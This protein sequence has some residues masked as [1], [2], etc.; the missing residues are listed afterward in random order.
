MLLFLLLD[1]LPSSPLPGICWQLSKRN[2][3]MS[4]APGEAEALKWND[5]VF[6]SCPRVFPQ[7]MAMLNL[8]LLLSE[9]YLGCLTAETGKPC[10]VSLDALFPARR[11]SPGSYCPQPIHYKDWAD[12]SPVLPCK[13]HRFAHVS[14]SCC[15]LKA[16]ETPRD[17]SLLLKHWQDP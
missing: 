5:L 2:F 14:G 3:L 7:P 9:L 8:L 6:F 11:A 15:Y 13:Q 10:S 12:A 16:I 1:H 17:S 4:S